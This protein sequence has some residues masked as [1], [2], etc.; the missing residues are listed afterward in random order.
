MSNLLTFFANQVLAKTLMDSIKDSALIAKMLNIFAQ[1]C[2][3]SKHFIELPSSFVQSVFQN[4]DSMLNFFLNE[5][6]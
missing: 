5:A 2:I 3:L 6:V 1:L 4:T